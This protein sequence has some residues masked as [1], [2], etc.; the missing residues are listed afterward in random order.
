M[1]LKLQHNFFLFLSLFF[2]LFTYSSYAAEK[3][4]EINIEDFVK[5]Q[6]DPETKDA[7]DPFIKSKKVFS[8]NE[9]HLFGI[10]HGKN[11]ALCLINDKI[12]FMNDSIGDYKV[13]HINKQRVLLKGA[14]GNLELSL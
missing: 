2:C 13:V 4:S 9:L 1:L 10:I 6:K 8:D 11:V 12:L 5:I 3:L 14:S 7:K